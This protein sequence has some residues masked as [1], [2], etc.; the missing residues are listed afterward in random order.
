MLLKFAGAQF[1]SIVNTTSSGPKGSPSLQLAFE[2]RLYSHTDPYGS[3]DRTI[4]GSV[5]GTFHQLRARFGADP[6][7]SSTDWR[8]SYNMPVTARS[9]SFRPMNGLRLDGRSDRPI[10]R[11]FPG[12][13]ASAPGGGSRKAL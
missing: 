9:R 13:R 2:V 10:L 7:F 11:T 8:Q 3:P 1:R 6:R 4:A 12:P 5:T